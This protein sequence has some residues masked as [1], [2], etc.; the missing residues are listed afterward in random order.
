M[1]TNKSEVK[2]F[3]SKNTDTWSIKGLKY[4]T[5]DPYKIGMLHGQAYNSALSIAIGEHKVSDTKFIFTE[6]LRQIQLINFLY[7]STLENI[8]IALDK[9]K[10]INLLNTVDESLIH[11]TGH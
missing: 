2:R 7:G 10:F 6:Y 1:V 4:Y 3:S 8:E 11:F 5:S 9:P